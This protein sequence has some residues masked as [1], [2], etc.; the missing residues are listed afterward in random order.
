[1]AD[2]N[3]VNNPRNI[4]EIANQAP[5]TDAIAPGAFITLQRLTCLAWV[6]G[7]DLLEFFDDPPSNR[8]IELQQSFLSAGGEPDG[9]GQGASLRQ[10][11]SP[12]AP[13]GGERS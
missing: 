6:A 7:G 5:I 10:R 9:P 13:A 2:A 11:G 3:D 12:S 8:R 1:M 4:R